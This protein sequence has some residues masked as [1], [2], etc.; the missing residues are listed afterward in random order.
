MHRMRR[1]RGSVSKRICNALYRGKGLS[2]GLPCRRGFICYTPGEVE[3]A[4]ENLG[5]GVCVVKAQVHAGGRGKAGGVK[6]AK[7]PMEARAHG[8]KILGM[9]LIT[10]QTGAEGKLVRKV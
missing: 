6:L 5:G 8:E 1:L 2:S 7:N 4:A 10:P 3:A 9:K